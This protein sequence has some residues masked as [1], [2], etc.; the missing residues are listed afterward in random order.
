MQR[1]EPTSKYNCI[2]LR[3]CIG[4]LDDREASQ[5]LAKLALSMVPTAIDPNKIV[6][7]VDKQ[8][9]YILLQD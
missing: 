2:V 7:D 3:Y 4:Y 5:F 1:F 6:S 9:S 8:A